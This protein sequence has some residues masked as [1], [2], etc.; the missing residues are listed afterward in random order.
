MTNPPK[1][2]G[3]STKLKGHDTSKSHNPWFG[4]RLM[5]L[6]HWL[7]WSSWNIVQAQ[8]VANTKMFIATLIMWMTMKMT[9][10]N[11]TDTQSFII[12][13]LFGSYNFLWYD[14]LITNDPS[15]RLGIGSGY[16][17]DM[18]Q[19]FCMTW[20]NDQDVYTSVI[21]LGTLNLAWLGSK[22]C[23]PSHNVVILQ[24]YWDTFSSSAPPCSINH[25]GFIGEYA[26]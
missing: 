14:P 12:M 5:C 10:L 15:M 18:S 23:T 22:W 1:R 20:T 24:S 13:T 7:D 8:N 3:S 11:S 19:G 16:K 2:D 17:H 26:A 9:L 4:V 25:L 21:K 6:V